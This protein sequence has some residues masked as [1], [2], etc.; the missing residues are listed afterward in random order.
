M[1][2]TYSETRVIDEN[3]IVAL[4][5]A[6]NW[7]AANK[8]KLLTKALL[9]SHGLVS[10]WEDEIL[11][12]IGNAISDGYLVVYYPHLL[13]HPDYQKRG[14][15]RNI[16]AKLKKKYENFHMH[17]LTA[18]GESIGFYEKSGFELAG[19]TRPMWIYQGDE[20]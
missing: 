15:G 2:I 16:I 7:T 8:P 9:N 13:V 17:M 12:G 3:Q 1:E 10:A 18:D 19:E 6:N 14:I 4:Y 11:V 5:L 20:H